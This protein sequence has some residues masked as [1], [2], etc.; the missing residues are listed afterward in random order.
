MIKL[1]AHRGYLLPQQRCKENYENLENSLLA[2]QQ[3]LAMNFPAIEFDI[4]YYQQNLYLKHNEPKDEELKMLPTLND[5]FA[6]TTKILGDKAS[7]IKYWCDFK[8]IDDNNVKKVLEKLKRSLQENEIAIDNCYFAPFITNYQLAEFVYQEFITFFDNK[9]KFVAVNDRI[10]NDDDIK[11]LNNFLQKNNIKFLSI[12]H[13]LINQNLIK[14]LPQD[15][16]YLAWTVNDFAKIK[17]LNKLQIE[18]FA[19]DVITPAMI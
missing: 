15:I 1:F 11:N 13:N 5:Y 17:E 2:L 4:W 3:A 16:K 14:K 19:T 6:K 18:Y 12:D 8:N 9:I 7:N 10:D